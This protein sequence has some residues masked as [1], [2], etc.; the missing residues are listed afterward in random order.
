MITKSPTF[1]Y[2]PFVSQSEVRILLCMFMQWWKWFPD[3]LYL[4]TT[5]MQDRYICAF[6]WHQ[7]ARENKPWCIYHKF[8]RYGS[9]VVSR[10]KHSFSRIGLD[11]HHELSNKYFKGEAGIE[12]M[13]G[14]WTWTN[15]FVT[16]S[17]INFINF[18]LCP[19]IL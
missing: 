6:V 16:W 15:T 7:N 4:I 12:I 18:K 10:T 19:V 13:L 11:H 8:S 14:Y 3:F 17:V 9:F 2:W 1:R 5:T